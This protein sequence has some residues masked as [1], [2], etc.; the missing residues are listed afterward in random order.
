M[1]V[2]N[3]Y[4]IHHILYAVHIGKPLPNNIYEDIND[5]NHKK[6]S[7]KFNNHE[8]LLRNSNEMQLLAT[9]NYP[10]GYDSCFIVFFL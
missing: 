4:T 10:I 8:N 9:N 5:T 2:N 1:L 7:N 3:F 6:T